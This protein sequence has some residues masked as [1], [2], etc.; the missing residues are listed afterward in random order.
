MR[1]EFG[2]I[3]LLEAVVGDFGA[4]RGSISCFGEKFMRLDLAG[5]HFYCFP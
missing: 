5:V 4:F 2:Q 1:F 3:E